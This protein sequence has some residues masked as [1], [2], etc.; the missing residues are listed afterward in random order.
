MDGGFDFVHQSLK[1][2]ATM[3]GRGT[4]AGNQLGGAWTDLK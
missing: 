1:E 2:L 4:V 3:A